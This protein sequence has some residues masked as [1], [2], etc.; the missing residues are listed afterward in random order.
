M[1]KDRLRHVLATLSVF[2]LA[3]GLIGAMPRKSEATPAAAVCL[4]A[5][6]AVVG[7]VVGYCIY[8]QAVKGNCK[9][10]PGCAPLPT[11]WC[12]TPAAA[13]GG[14]PAPWQFPCACKATQ[15]WSCYC[16]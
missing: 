6:G 13:C 8:D 1:M 15:L 9:V 16:G 3:L 10:P 5:P 2:C 4:I 14:P 7:G 11:G 12:V